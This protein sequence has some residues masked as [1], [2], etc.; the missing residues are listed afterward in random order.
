MIEAVRGKGVNRARVVCDVCG[1]DDTVP[2]GYVRTTQT[3]SEPNRGQVLRKIEGSGWSEIKGT[4]RCPSC[5]AKRKILNE[6]A[7]MTVS[8]AKTET[9]R[10]PS[11]KQKREII[12][13]LEIVYDD[14]RKRFKDGE[15]DKTVAEAVGGGVLF[16]WVAQVREE[17]FGPDS[18]NKEIDA[19]RAEIKAVEAAMGEVKGE[20]RKAVEGL[21]SRVSGL[22]Q[23]LEKVTQ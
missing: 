16:G 2:C 5:E 17:L 6:G 8:E 20:F 14:E 23:S 15:S 3:T 1:R 11:P 12:G 7:K 18:R 4:L 10:S 21:E 19:I 22:R 13:M 9:L